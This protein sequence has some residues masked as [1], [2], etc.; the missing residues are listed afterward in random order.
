VLSLAPTGTVVADF[1]IADGD[2]FPPG[3][4][5]ASGRFGAALAARAPNSTWNLLVGAPGD[6]GK[7]DRS[8]RR[9]AQKYEE[10]RRFSHR[11]VNESVR[12]G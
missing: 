8:Q 7:S 10:F 6:D 1:S 5:G 11:S 12:Y 2:G 3:Q 9:E 4:L